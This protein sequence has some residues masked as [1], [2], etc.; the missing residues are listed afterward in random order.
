MQALRLLFLTSAIIAMAAGFAGVATA[1]DRNNP[2]PN[3]HVMTVRL[4]DGSTE[5][6]RYWGDRLPVVTFDDGSPASSFEQAFDVFD[7]G[8]PFAELERISAAMDRQ[9]AAMLQRASQL[10]GWSGSS[11][12]TFN[13]DFGKLPPG[14][15]GYSVVSTI[16]NG[17]TCTQTIRYFSSGNGKPQV[18]KSSSGNCGAVR[19]RSSRPL[20]AAIPKPV[21]KPK[22]ANVIEAKYNPEAPDDQREAGGIQMA[23]LF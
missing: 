18:E 16:S 10:D 12:G 6:I 8:S 7:M 2:R 4:P 21:A 17:Q 14:T 9:A 23:G 13:I 20:R 22:P 15:R 3:S 11:D 19:D 1:Q 5:Q